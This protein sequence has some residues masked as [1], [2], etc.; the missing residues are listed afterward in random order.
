MKVQLANSPVSWGVDYAD[1]AKNPPWP[2]VLTEIAKVGY[3]CTE[4]GPYG[5]LPTDAVVLKRELAQ[6]GLSLIA[7]F[8]FQPLDEPTEANQIL[9]LAKKTV[10]LLSAVGGKYLVTIDKICTPRMSTAGRRDLAR[11]LDDR[12]FRHMADLIER[13]ADMALAHG[14][15]PVIHQHAGTYIEFEDEL[16]RLLAALDAAK[17]G[18]CLDTGHMSY[19]GIDPLAFYQHHAARVK[20]LHFKDVDPAVHARALAD[21]TPFIDAVAARIFCPL[22]KGV[23][24]WTELAKLLAKTGYD[25]AATIEQDV[26][27]TATLGSAKDAEISLAFLRS[28][29]F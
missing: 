3:R 15:M 25:G 20:Y 17:V 19:A 24:K 18:I 1:N 12:R 5:Y 8:I 16:E 22:G 23:V 29:G 7:G 4:L 10:T 6:R 26:D 11:R 21:K 27:P 13:I 9:E 28:V 14:V 2:G